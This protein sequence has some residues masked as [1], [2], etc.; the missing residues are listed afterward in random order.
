MISFR[1]QSLYITDACRGIS[2]Y[3]NSQ[4]KMGTIRW[5]IEDDEGG[6]HDLIIPESIYMPDAR[7]IKTTLPPTLGTDRD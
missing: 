7:N 2:G 5:E 4:V 3:T 6:V 1:L